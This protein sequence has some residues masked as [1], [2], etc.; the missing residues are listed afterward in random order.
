MGDQMRGPFFDHYVKLVVALALLLVF[1]VYQWSLPSWCERVTG[2]IL[3]RTPSDDPHMNPSVTYKYPLPNGH[4]ATGKGHETENVRDS[5]APGNSVVVVRSPIWPYWA[6]LEAST[7]HDKHQW[8]TMSMI[9]AGVLSITLLVRALDRQC[10]KRSVAPR[11]LD[12]AVFGVIRFRGGVWDGKADLSR[13]C[14]G[15]TVSIFAPEAG[16]SERQR[17]LFAELG[18]YFDDL[19][20]AMQ[21]PLYDEYQRIRS[22]RGAECDWS[23]PGA[24]D[25]FEADYPSVSSPGDVWSAATLY[26]IEVYEGTGIDFCFVHEIRWADEHQLNVNVKDWSV[27]DVAFE[28]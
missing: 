16:P 2:I 15:V 28:G 27:V 13:G 20:A 22:A 9:F 12:D 1:V 19:R 21:R 6:T 14:S 25:D 5:F 24:M 26:L 4:W 17:T 18:R 3:T 8:A 11:M 7:H 23:I 10:A